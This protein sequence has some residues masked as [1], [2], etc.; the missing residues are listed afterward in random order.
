LPK[1]M[2]TGYSLQANVQRACLNHKLLAL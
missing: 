1:V 2:A